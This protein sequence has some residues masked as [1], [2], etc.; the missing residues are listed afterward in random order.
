M[1]KMVMKRVEK[2]RVKNDEDVGR[3]RSRYMYLKKDGTE[4]VEREG[5]RA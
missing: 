2:K 1:M 3:R 4:F 5:G